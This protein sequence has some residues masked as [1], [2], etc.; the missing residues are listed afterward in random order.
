VHLSGPPGISGSLEEGSVHSATVDPYRVLG[1]DASW[2][3][4]EIEA[5]YRELVLQHHPDLHRAEGP[6]AVALAERRTVLLNES[7][8]RIRKEHLVQG[9]AGSSHPRGSTGQGAEDG[10][11]WGGGRAR[12]ARPR[13]FK[14]ADTSSWATGPNGEDFGIRYQW[15]PPPD[16]AE[17]RHRRERRQPCPFCGEDFAELAAFEAHL[18]TEHGWDYRNARPRTAKRRA[19][20][21][22]VRG[23]KFSRSESYI[24]ILAMCCCA[25]MVGLALWFRV[26]NL[27]ALART[28]LDPF[29]FLLVL[30]CSVIGLRIAFGR[31]K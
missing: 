18:D 30:F 25:V 17:E 13:G 24:E 16:D 28:M 27:S 2:T 23:P 14:E 20:R 9:F 22:P 31:R 1:V 19:K 12:T 11:G 26:T 5:R 29:I 10:R 7:M 4:D 15:P 21:A 6:E 8:A 3:L